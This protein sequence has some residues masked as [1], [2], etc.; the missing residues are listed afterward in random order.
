MLFLL[1]MLLLVSVVIL[2]SVQV[3]AGVKSYVSFF[4]AKPGEQNSILCDP[5]HGKLTKLAGVETRSD[6]LFLTKD[7]AAMKLPIKYWFNFDK[8]N[9]LALDRKITDHRSAACQNQY[10]DYSKLPNASIIMIFYNEP[11]S[12]LFRSII[13]ILD[14]T[15]PELLHEF[16]FV[17]DGGSAPWI[18]KPLDDFVASNPKFKLIRTGKQSGL[19]RARTQ[20]AMAA[21]GDVLIFLDSH[22]ETG[23]GWIEPM[24]KRIQDDRRNVIVPL[25]DV[26]DW[27]NFEVR[28]T[29]PTVTGFRWDMILQWISIPNEPG[30]DTVPS[31]T[32]P[33]GLFAMSRTYFF[34]LGGYDLGMEI[35]GGE[36]LEL[37]F[38]VWTCGGRVEFA[39]CS[40]VTHVFQDGHTYTVPGSTVRVNSLRLAATWLDEYADVVYR[41][42]GQ[43][44]IG[45]TIGGITRM[46][47]LRKDRQ[48]KPFKW[49]LENV[50]PYAVNSGQ[51]V[52]RAYGYI[53][54]MEYNGCIDCVNASAQSRPPPVNNMNI[55]PHCHGSGSAQFILWNVD[56]EIVIHH[57]TDICFDAISQTE[58]KLMSCHRQHGNQAWHWDRDTKLI[59]SLSQNRCLKADNK[60]DKYE[61]SLEACDALEKKQQWEFQVIMGENSL[62]AEQEK[63][64]QE[65]QPVSNELED[66]FIEMEAK[67]LL[68]PQD[69]AHKPQ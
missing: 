67:G 69:Q 30:T 66:M 46:S 55:Y 58:V 14:R 48:C 38:R 18:G 41:F 31:P 33:G 42:Q 1:V 57:P 39:P 61:F 65:Q 64:L 13:S 47:K 21:T 45:T 6:G 5:C 17:E 26:T 52:I 23:D 36:N 16:V 11:P 2:I 62:A 49:Y 60:N 19:M 15:P 43:S 8:S 28:R 44:P 10:F 12:T 9:E 40:R 35:W 34:E 7:L 20:G 63:A 22:I 27:D 50:S 56:D 37:A 51:K 59:K 54:N 68:K 53:K 25:V 3:S 32:M 4:S 24:L 29:S